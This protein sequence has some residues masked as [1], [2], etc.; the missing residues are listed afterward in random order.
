VRA[1]ARLRVDPRLVRRAELTDAPAEWKDLQRELFD[2]QRDVVTGQNAVMRAFWMDDAQRLD[3]FRVEHQRAPRTKDEWPAP[4]LDPYHLMRAVSP[5]IPSAMA[6]AA[7][8]NVWQKWSSI[9]Y[10]ALVRQ[11]VSP[12]HYRD[13]APIPL[14]AKELGAVKSGEDYL[15]TFAL[16]AGRGQ[17]WQVRIQPRDDYQKRTLDAIAAGRWLHGNALLERDRRNRW[18][19]RI[20]YKRLAPVTST[21]KTAAINRG[22]RVFLACVTDSDERWLYD[23][24]DIAA[25]LKQIQERRKNYQ[26]DAK[27]AARG[28]RGRK[29]ILRPIQHLTDKAGRWR[30]TKCQTIARRLVRWLVDRGVK[31]LLVEDFERIRDSDGIDNK[32]I[33]QLVQEWPYYQLEQR[34]RSCCAEAGIE[35]VSLSPHY[36][37]QQCPKCGHTDED[38]RDLRYWQLKCGECGY[39]EHLD[40][41][42]ARNLLGRERPGGD[43]KSSPETQGKSG[44]PDAA[45]GGARKA[46][47]KS[48]K[49]NGSAPT[50]RGRRG[51]R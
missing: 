38:N 25:Y 31:T 19:I 2:A 49:S 20:A 5:N 28:S 8:R 27:A 4:T 21:G 47:S 30:A 24:N 23:G 14:R 13:T 33:V 48:S 11:K 41:A 35:V 46:S 9:R 32:H 7:S 10:D 16:R 45:P 34:I 12:P 29:R 37:S 51:K 36:L 3:A 50:P 22:L 40:A 44:G 39:R 43:A 17:R 26:R 6:G 18:Y 15:I 1:T 42:A